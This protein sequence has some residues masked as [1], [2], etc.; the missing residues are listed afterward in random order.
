MYYQAFLDVSTAHD[1][2]GYLG[3]KTRSY[4]GMGGLTCYASSTLALVALH[5]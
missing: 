5:I 1:L 3:Q 4:E 2:E